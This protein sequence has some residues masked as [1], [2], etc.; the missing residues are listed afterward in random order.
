MA[1]TRKE[2]GRVLE[3]YKKLLEGAKNVIVMEQS[4][5]PVNDVV[6]LRKGAALG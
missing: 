5:I 6:R 4:S 1:L 2:K 3:E